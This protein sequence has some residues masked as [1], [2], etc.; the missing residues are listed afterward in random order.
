MIGKVYKVEESSD[1]EF[2]TAMEGEWPDDTGPGLCFINKTDCVIINSPKSYNG[3][4]M[5]HRFI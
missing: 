5:K 2:W 4:G 3:E 1:V